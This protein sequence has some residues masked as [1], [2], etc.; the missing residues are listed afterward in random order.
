MAPVV[1]TF[2]RVNS[3]VVERTQKTCGGG[4][5]DDVCSLAASTTTV[6]EELVVGG[7]WV[8]GFRRPLG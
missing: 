4:I 8:M 6:W 3:I 7:G 1:A 2:R 5:W